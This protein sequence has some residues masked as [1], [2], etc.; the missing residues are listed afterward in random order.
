MT[1]DEALELFETT[2]HAVPNDVEAIHA[3]ADSVLILVLEKLGYEKLTKA[4]R[5]VPKWYA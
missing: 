3:I 5:E 1:D 4:W 2:V